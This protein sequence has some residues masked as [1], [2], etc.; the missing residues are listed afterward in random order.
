M[1]NIIFIYIILII[2]ISNTSYCI[3]MTK[4]EVL[5]I[6]IKKYK[7]ESDCPKYSDGYDEKNKHC[8]FRFFCRD[9]YCSTPDENGIVK[10]F[11]KEYQLENLN[12]FSC[13]SQFNSTPTCIDDR[14]AC[15]KD[16]D[17]FTNNCS[18]NVCIIKSGSPTTEC[19]D[20]YYYSHLLYIYKA[21]MHCGLGQ[22]EICKKDKDCASK[23]CVLSNDNQVKT[24]FPYNS[25][26]DISK[27]RLYD[28]L[29]KV[30]IFIGCIF[31]ATIINWF[32][33]KIKS[34]KSNNGDSD[35]EYSI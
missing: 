9:D 31:V 10:L 19:I 33:S 16:S 8:T 18:N 12:S 4:K 28:I 27:K 20:E 14:A 23:T 17:C 21:K 7:K 29:M 3:T 32:K 34:K 25:R 13:S 24:C 35:S 2:L 30:V 26:K 22:Y 11:N 5:D 6:D 1:L 15:T